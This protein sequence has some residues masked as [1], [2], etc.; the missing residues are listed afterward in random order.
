MNFCWLLW[1]W[2]SKG[3]PSSC[4]SDTRIT[5]IHQASQQR[6]RSG[7]KSERISESSGR[8]KSLATSKEH[9]P[10]SSYAVTGALTGK[11]RKAGL[12]RLCVLMKHLW[13]LRK[14]CIQSVLCSFIIKGTGLMDAAL[15]SHAWQCIYHSLLYSE[16]GWGQL[17]PVALPTL[18]K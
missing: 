5:D 3:N 8:G 14:Q 10:N 16:T 9:H 13:G 2:C 1:L 4:K 17:H 6:K 12:M 7:S 11:Q 15:L 18:L